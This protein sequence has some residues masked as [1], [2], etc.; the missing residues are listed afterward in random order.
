MSD[1]VKSVESQRIHFRLLMTKEHSELQLLSRLYRKDIIEPIYDEKN[2]QPLTNYVHDLRPFD[3][4]T[5]DHDT[6]A[7]DLS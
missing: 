3:M 6:A 4:Y 5:I 2:I 7:T 1:L